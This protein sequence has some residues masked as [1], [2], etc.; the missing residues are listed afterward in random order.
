MKIQASCGNAPR[1][2]SVT[3]TVYKLTLTADTQGEKRWLAGLLKAVGK[4]SEWNT[5][6]RAVVPELSICESLR[7]YREGR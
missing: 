1:T 5:R 7:S 6:L 2:A 4:V 3:D